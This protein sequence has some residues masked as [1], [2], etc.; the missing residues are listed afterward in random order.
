MHTSLS[1]PCYSKNYKKDQDEQ[2][3]TMQKRKSSLYMCKVSQKNKK[4][5]KTAAKL[6][7]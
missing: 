6:K 7:F 1:N 3:Y 5:I 4:I 2:K